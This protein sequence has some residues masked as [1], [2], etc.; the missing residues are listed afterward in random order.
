MRECS[1]VVPKD[2]KLMYDGLFTNDKSYLPYMPGELFTEH[3]IY[4]EII[5]TQ[6]ESIGSESVYLVVKFKRFMH[7]PIYYT[8]IIIMFL[9][10]GIELLYLKSVFY[11]SRVK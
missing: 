7:L 1:E 4:G 5:G 6:P 3:I 9:L 2:V 8:L 11:T 10:M